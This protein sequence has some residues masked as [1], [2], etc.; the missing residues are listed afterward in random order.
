MT[1]LFNITINGVVKKV[2]SVSVSKVINRFYDVAVFNIDEDVQHE[3]DVVINYGDDSFHGFVFSTIKISKTM[4]SIECRTEGAKLTEPYSAYTEGFD[5]ATTSHELCA[6]Y[7]T[8]SGVPINITA[9]DLDFGGSYERVGTMLSA[10][11]NIA[12]TTG[13]EFWDDG[14]SI[15]IQP[16]KAI[17]SQ[18]VE[19]NPQDIFDFVGTKS[20]V[21]NKGVGVITIQNGGSETT[22]IIS[23]NRIYAEIDECS[24]ELFVF[25]NPYGAIEHTV[26]ISPLSPIKI[27]RIETNSMLDI[28]VITLDGAIDSI[29]SIKL[30]GD[31]ISDYNFEQGHN[32]LWF[33]SLKRGTLTV[34]Y[35]ASAYKGYTNITNVPIGRFITFDIFYLDQLLRFEGLLSPNCLNSATDGDM[36]CIV[37]SDNYYNAGFNAWTI[38]GDPVFK[39]FNGSSEIIRTVVSTSDDYISVEDATLEEVIGVGYRYKTRYVLGTA[40]GVQSNGDGI[41]YTTS[42]DGDDYYFEFTQYYPSVKVSYNTPATKH[43]V[44]FSEITGGEIIMVIMNNN[45]DQTCEYEL[46]TKIRCVFNQYVDVDVASELGIEVTDVSGASLSYLKPNGS[47]STVSVNV[48]GIAKIYVFMDGDYVIDTTSLKARTYIT[49]TSNVN[50]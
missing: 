33:N 22:D 42:V 11:Q 35:K 20:T 13:A 15:Q 43:Y 12:T 7:A 3:L 14:S 45:T 2:D 47:A 8:T 6:L 34:E 5:E 26:G 18:G 27:D 46:D 30:N 41:S 9:G 21:Y 37:P 16:N 38:G 44:Q 50:G 36:T 40:L 49:L 23:K 31:D 19:I 10:L 4:Y 1:Q 17:T 39:F 48:F 29:T 32:V 24:G 25:P 28:D